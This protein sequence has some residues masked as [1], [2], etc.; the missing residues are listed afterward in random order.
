[1]VRRH[2]RLPRP[3]RL[4][5]A[6]GAPRRPGPAI[7]AWPA[8]FPAPP[9]R[10]VGPL[11]RAPRA[12]PGPPFQGPLASLFGPLLLPSAAPDGCTVVGRLAQTLDGRIAT[13]SGSSQWIGGQGD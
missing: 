13:V 5:P 12:G 10:Q 6:A 8:G 1:M 3:F 7:R 11:L 2:A 4:G 9:P